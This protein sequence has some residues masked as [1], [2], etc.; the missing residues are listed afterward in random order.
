MN[1]D[2]TIHVNGPGLDNY[3]IMTLHE[4]KEQPSGLPGCTDATTVMCEIGAVIA[5]KTGRGI[6]ISF[7][8]IA[9]GKRD[10]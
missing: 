3:Q 1:N 9:E 4:D 8:P 10:E 6:Q 7:M 2:I 5:K